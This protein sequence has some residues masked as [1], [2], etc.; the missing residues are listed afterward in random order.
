MAKKFNKKA[1][2]KW[3]D[4]LCRVVV[5]ER[6]GWQCRWCKKSQLE[7][8]DCQWSHIN[9]RTTNCV[10]WDLLNSL[11]LCSGCHGDAHAHET[12]FYGWLQNKHPYLLDYLNEEIDG[13]PR[14]KA[15]TLWK[16]DNFLAVE[17]ALLLKALDLDVD[18]YKIKNDDGGE[19]GT[20]MYRKRL[21]KK[22]K[23]VSK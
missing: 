4:A 8:L 19:K 23:E 18:P 17:R 10:R 14:C 13:V 1:F 6:D 2:K 9:S 11:T 22:L 15:R 5:K 21:I 20:E 16:E 3:L 12:V 7:G